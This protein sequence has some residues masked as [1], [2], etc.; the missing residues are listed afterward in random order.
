MCHKTNI[1]S[2]GDS[3]VLLFIILYGGLF[4]SQYFSQ[5]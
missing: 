3:N 1:S 5:N 2:S 4:N